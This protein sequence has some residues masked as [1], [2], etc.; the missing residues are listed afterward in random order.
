MNAKYFCW[1]HNNLDGDEPTPSAPPFHHQEEQDSTSTSLYP[2]C[3]SSGHIPVLRIHIGRDK[4]EPKV[5]SHMSLQLLA[6]TIFTQRGTL[7]G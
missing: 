1:K 3:M 2:R 7:E 5:P 6:E 4:M